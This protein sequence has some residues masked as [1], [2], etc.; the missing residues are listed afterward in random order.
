MMDGIEILEWDERDYGTLF[1]SLVKL[2]LVN[3]H[4]VSLRENFVTDLTL[5]R[6]LLRVTAPV[7]IALSCGPEALATLEAR[8]GL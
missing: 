7:H 8:E 2:L 3:F 1:S 5:E 6:S 4:R